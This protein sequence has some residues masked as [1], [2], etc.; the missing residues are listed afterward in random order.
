MIFLSAPPL[1]EHFIPN[2]LFLQRPPRPPP[3]PRPREPV[4]RVRRLVH[5]DARWLRP[6][7]PVEPEQP[8]ALL[9]GTPT[10]PPPHD[11]AAPPCTPSPTHLT[12]PLPVAPSPPP[13]S[14]RPLSA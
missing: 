9:H 13:L 6:V 11:R 2:E 10:N 8:F 14:P 4:H 7:P 5:D 1:L 3:A 12:P